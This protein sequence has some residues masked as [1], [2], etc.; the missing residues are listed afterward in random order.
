MTLREESKAR[1]VALLAAQAAQHWTDPGRA[2][3]YAARPACASLPRDRTRTS[4]ATLYDPPAGGRRS[5][6]TPH[7]HP[8]GAT[9]LLHHITTAAAGFHYH[10]TSTTLPAAAVSTTPHLRGLERPAPHITPFAAAT[11]SIAGP[12]LCA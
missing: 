2:A 9:P 5:F 11:M 1:E 10:L 8:L 3:A 4:R 12:V 6:T 7:Q